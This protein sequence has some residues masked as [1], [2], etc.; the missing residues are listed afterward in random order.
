[1][2]MPAS[3]NVGRFRDSFWSSLLGRKLGLVGVER[4]EH[5]LACTR[6]LGRRLQTDGR[7]LQVLLKRKAEN[8]FAGLMRRAGMV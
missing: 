5:R 6:G 2:Q 4:R 8:L 1:M 3:Q 7:S